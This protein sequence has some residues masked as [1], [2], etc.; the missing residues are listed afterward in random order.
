MPD[1]KRFKTSE[2]EGARQKFRDVDIQT[3]V[4]GTN[5][6]MAIYGK[7]EQDVVVADFTDG[8]STVGTLVLDGVLPKGAIFLFAKVTNIVGFAGDTTAVMTI[9]DGSDVDRYNTGTINVFA[10]DEP[11]VE[12]G[13]PSGAKLLEA[14]NAP[15]LTITGTA[16]FTSIVSDGNGAAKIVLYY[17][18]A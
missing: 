3:P 12:A 2:V 15:T 9:G 16:D 10:T 17:I 13:V 1:T 18:D 5:R 4:G 8:G 11:G 6:T 14:D 7:I